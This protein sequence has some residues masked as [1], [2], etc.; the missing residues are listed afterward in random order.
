MGGNF[1]QGYPIPPPPHLP[2]FE[3]ATTVLK[4]LVIYQGHDDPSSKSYLQNFW[5]LFEAAK[6][7]GPV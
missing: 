5:T 7:H 6:I 1:E 2:L 4:L 3:I